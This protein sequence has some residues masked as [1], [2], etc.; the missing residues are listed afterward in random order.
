MKQKRRVP[1]LLARGPF[2]NWGFDQGVDAQMKLN[3]DGL[4]ELEVMATWPTYVQLNV[5]GFDNY[6]YG[7]VDGDGV[8]ERLPPNTLSANYLNMSK[9]PHPYV[10]WEL[11]VDDATLTW[12][13]CAGNAMYS[14]YR[15]TVY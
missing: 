10:A 12:W 7:D 4:W 5:F 6:F 11:V 1:Q 9:P 13:L 2:N 15:R 8:M 14:Y 3:D